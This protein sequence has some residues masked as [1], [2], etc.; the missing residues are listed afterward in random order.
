MC[1]AILNNGSKISREHFRNSL[2]NNSDGFGMAY[3]EKNTLKVFKSLSTNFN[4]LYQKYS[5]VFKKTESP[6]LLHFR[7]ST[8]GGVNLEN[9]HPFYIHKDL[10]MVH[11]GIIGGY[12]NKKENDTRHYIRDILTK[13][14]TKELMDNVSLKTLIERDISGSKFVFFDSLGNFNILNEK[15]GHWDN[16]NNW[17]SNN[18]Y[19]FS[20][21]NTEFVYKPTS[22]SFDNYGKCESCLEY[23]TVKHID[24]LKSYVCKDCEEFYK[25]EINEL[26][27]WH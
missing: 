2:E 27:V 24:T 15:A 23:G 22:Q 7:I 19:K 18:T 5:D 20:Y 9:C 17:F 21:Y 4:T 13:F 14:E 25:D 8:G 16:N 1:I 6:I 26:K 10:V 11:N 12:G 3:I